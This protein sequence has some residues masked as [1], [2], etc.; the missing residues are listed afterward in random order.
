MSLIANVFITI[1]KDLTS[2]TVP[3][4]IFNKSEISKYT[5]FDLYL[6]VFLSQL[7]RKIDEGGQ[8]N[9]MYLT[10]VKLYYFLYFFTNKNK[11]LED[12]HAITFNRS[13]EYI[14][15]NNL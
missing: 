13:V 12:G 3:I 8:S 15:D 2:C 5:H 10:Y 6:T 9:E 14:F 4:F 11:V 1:F 7:Q